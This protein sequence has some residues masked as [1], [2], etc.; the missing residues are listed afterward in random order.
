MDY[1]VAAGK[2]RAVFEVKG[3]RNYQWHPVSQ[4]VCLGLAVNEV[5]EP[6]S[7]DNKDLTDKVAAIVCEQF[8]DRVMKVQH[9]APMSQIVFFNDAQ[10]TTREDIDLVLGKL[11]VS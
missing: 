6:Y 11:E 9:T 7:Q 4:A 8:P 2:I 1:A 5:T 3:W 10:L